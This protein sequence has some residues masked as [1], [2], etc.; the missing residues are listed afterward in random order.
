MHPGTGFSGHVQLIDAAAMAVNDLLSQDEIDA[1]LHGVSG[2]EF[3]SGS[4]DGVGAQEVRQYDFASEDRIFRA[5]M[6]ALEAVNERF[7]RQFRGSVFELLRGPAEVS[8]GEVE[9]MKFAE[10]LQTLFIPSSLHAVTV[11]PLRGSALVVLDPALVSFAVDNFFGGDG[12]Y[13]VRI[14]GREFTMAERR[15]I[16]LLLEGA[17]SNLREAWAPVVAADFELAE[18]NVS[19]ECACIVSSSDVVVTSKFHVELAGGG[20][21]LHVTM[22]YTMLEPVRELLDAGVP[23]EGAETDARWFSALREEITGA[24][25]ELSA[26]LNEAELSL[27]DV[28][29]M[30]AGDIIPIRAPD[31]VALRA[32]GV[33]LFRARLGQ[34]DD[35]L[36]VEILAPVSGG[37]EVDDRLGVHV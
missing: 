25:V 36:A 1:L 4:S 7:A 3:D 11:R 29:N 31:R 20:G 10:Y 16:N 18:S 15:V 5:R 6:P 21:E 28:L 37:Y 34:S 8:P 22:P 17:L 9:M 35:Y 12:R 27:R 30:K 33:P 32:E 13:P 26:T 14:E 24:D 19:P 2:L 23:G